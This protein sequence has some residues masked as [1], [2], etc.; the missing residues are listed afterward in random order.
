[1]IRIAALVRAAAAALL[2]AA[3]VAN[4]AYTVDC[5]FTGGGD[6]ISR[7]FYV[8]NY[9][10]TS[11]GTVTL[12]HSAFAAGERTITLT[13]RLSTFNG[14]SLGI[15]SVTRVIG[16]TMSKSV[17]DFGDVPVAAGSRITFSQTIIS[18]D[19]TSVF[20]DTG[21]G[22]CTNVNETEDTSPPLSSF[23]RNSVGLLITGNPTSIAA[24]TNV[25]CPWVPGGGGDEIDRGFY[26]T[27][28]QG[29]TI[30]TV[31]LRHS[32][33]NTGSKTI[34]L[35][36]RLYSYD[37]PLVGAVTVTR[38]VTGT[39][40]DTVFD[41][42]NAAVPAG[43]TI[44]FTQVLN[45]GST[46]VFFDTGFTPCD[47]VTETN[48]TTPP[49]DFFRRQS[50]GVKIV[51]R[52]ASA[53]AIHVVEYH[54]SVF[55]HYFM[56]ADPAEIAGLDGGAYGGVFTRTGQEF[57]ARDGPVAGTVDV[58]RFFTTPGDFG[59]KSSHFYTADAAECAGVKLN[60]HWIYEKI[61]FYIAVPAGGVCGGGLVPVYRM[62][63][64]GMTG[65]PNHRFTTSLAI[66]TQFTTTL[67]WA[68]EGIRFCAIPL[69]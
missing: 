69:V 15:A 12:A 11:L 68:P 25:D 64:N 28:Y 47:D 42:G 48:G 67:G 1:M 49:L 51:G 22:P 24:A 16:T 62:Y 38:N 14:T 20:F 58:C 45:A 57:L 43:S 7:G 6:L 4:A 19:A 50:A 40:T 35:V 30:D 23:R 34:T 63:N 46:R 52:V 32:T 33:D 55:D 44:T 37:G 53:S 60:P 66:Y 21:V 17:F 41:F 2:L 26:V 59:T 5:P 18:G 56:T 54:H 10:G 8:D 3:P 9:Q 39:G 13:A 61:A 31:T 29:T 36:V 65:A 27:N